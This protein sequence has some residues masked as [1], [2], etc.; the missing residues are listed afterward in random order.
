MPLA[1]AEAEDHRFEPVVVG[2][3]EHVRF[4]V[5]TSMAILLEE[6]SSAANCPCS[7][8]RGKPMSFKPGFDHF[9]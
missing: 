2:L 5:R 8:A 3:T 9:R 4:L 6:T 7:D 1:L